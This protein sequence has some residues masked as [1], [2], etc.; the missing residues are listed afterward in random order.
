MKNTNY[1]VEVTRYWWLPMITGLVSIAIG[2]WCLCSPESSLPTLAYAFCICLCATG[3]LNFVYAVGNMGRHYSWGWS[4]AYGIIEI[5]CA[6]WLFTLPIAAMTTAFIYAIGIY[7][8]FIAINAICEVCTL[9]SDGS[10]WMGWFMALLLATIV[11]SFIFLAGPIAGGIA[12]WLYIGISF[13]C[14]GV[15]RIFLSAKLRKINKTIQF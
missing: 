12:V 11:C 3:I 4:L 14:Y 9:Y 8:I 15:Y 7:L 10:F 5:L 13:I 1:N 6:I 2:V